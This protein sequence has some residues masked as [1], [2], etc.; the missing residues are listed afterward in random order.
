MGAKYNFK[1]IHIRQDDYF[2]RFMDW[3]DSSPCYVL[4]YVEPTGPFDANEMS[5]SIYN[6]GDFIPYHEHQ[7]G[8]EVFLIDNG[9]VECHIRGKRAVAHKG[10]MVVITPYVP[11]GFIFLEDGVIWREL[12]Q[13]IQ[14]NDGILQL[15]RVREYHPETAKDPIFKESVLRRDGTDFFDWRPKLKSVDKSEIPQIR[16]YDYAIDRFDFE[17]ISFLQKATRLEA[18]GYKE[19]W[20]IRANRGI[21]MGWNEWNPHAIL[22]VVYAGSVYVQLD[23]MEPFTAEERDI[24]SIPSYMAGSLRFKEDTVMLD[25]NCRGFLYRALEE[26]E[27]CGDDAAKTDILERADHYIHWR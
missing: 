18:N 13:E 20:Q 11:H 3:D 23:G 24:L 10:D 1:K 19:V 12:F 2:A 17:G 26:M 6:K 22:F 16:P 4:Y 5:D 15:N 14:M 7:R 8:M 21:E 27:A 25:Y 9:S